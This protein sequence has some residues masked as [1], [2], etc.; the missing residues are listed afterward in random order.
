M[1]NRCRRSSRVNS[2]RAIERRDV[3][4]LQVVEEECKRMFRAR[5]HADESPEDQLKTALRFRG[6][7]SGTDGCSPMRCFS[8]GTSSTMS[9]PLDPRLAKGIAPFA[10][11]IFVLAQEWAD[12]ALKRLCQ[13]GVRNVAFVLVELA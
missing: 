5:E 9:S 7:S 12:E 10:Q 11:F 4:P 3:Q 2:L 1:S 6:G 13:R 8:S